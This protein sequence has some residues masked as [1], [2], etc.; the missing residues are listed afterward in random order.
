[1]AKLIKRYLE[2]RER[3]WKNSGRRSKCPEEIMRE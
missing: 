3:Y 2:G 1:M